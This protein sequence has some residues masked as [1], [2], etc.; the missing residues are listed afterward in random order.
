M[1][2]LFCFPEGIRLARELK[3]FINFN[4]ILTT[5]T[6]DRFYCNCLTFKESMESSMKE[7]IGLSAQDS[8]Y[9]EKT[10]CLVSKQRYT[11]E[12]AESLKHLYRLSMSKND[13]PF[14]RVVASFV[15]G[16][17]LPKDLG[18]NGMSYSYGGSNINFETNPAYPIISVPPVLYRKDPFTASS[19]FCPSRPSSA[20]SSQYFYRK[21]SFSSPSPRQCW[22]TQLR[23]FLPSFFP[24]AGSMF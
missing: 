9:Y 22:A 8:I 17:C 10:L 14:D 19:S 2:P 11:D 7:A 24:S 12:F 21:R 4:F 6:G 20:S 13:V 15:D 23:P 5:E 16:L 1:M 18:I 3:G